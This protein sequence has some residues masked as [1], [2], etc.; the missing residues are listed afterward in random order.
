VVTRLGEAFT[1]YVDGNSLGSAQYDVFVPNASYPLTIGQA[2]GLGYLDGRIDDVQIYNVALTQDEVMFLTD[3][4]GSVVTFSC[5]GDLNGDG[6]VDGADLGL[7]LGSWG[8]CG[9]CAANLDGQG[10]VDGADLGILLGAWGPC[11]SS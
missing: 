8:P 3:N 9:A 2:E 5:P 4:T 6:G 7:L 1:F 10:G 11:P